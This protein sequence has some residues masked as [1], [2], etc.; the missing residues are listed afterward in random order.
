M[1]KYRMYITLVAL[2]F[3]IFFLLSALTVGH[4]RKNSPQYFQGKTL[5]IIVGSSSGGGFDTYTR[6]SARHIGK[7][8]PG[9]LNII[10]Q[11][12]SGAGG[13]VTA[14]HLYYKAKPDGLTLGVFHEGLVLDRFLNPDKY[15]SALVD[16]EKFEWIGAPNRVVSVCGI[17]ESTGL[18]TWK[19]IASSDKQIKMGAS[20]TPGSALDVLPKMFNRALGIEKFKIIAGYLGST[21]VQLALMRQEVDGICLGWDSLKSSS[22]LSSTAPHRFIPF[23]TQLSVNDPKYKNLTLIPG[24]IRDSANDALEKAYTAWEQSRSFS[25]ALTA[26]PG[27]PPQIVRILRDAY[28]KTLRDPQLLKEAREMDIE[29]TH[30]SAN[31]IQ[32]AIRSIRLMTP[33]ARDL[34]QE[35]IQ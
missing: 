12:M 3:S 17:M 28:E 21:Q 34:L 7:Y 27:T 6:L 10:V 32:N 35:M 23:V 2:A 19:D 11:N 33:T 4:A 22:L 5:T 20:G 1:K 30:V 13:L 25:K 14:R 26:P 16:F 9:N 18:K 8:I 31:D 15:T 29:I 24:I